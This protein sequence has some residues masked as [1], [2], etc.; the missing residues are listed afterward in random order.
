MDSGRKGS[1]KDGTEQAGGIYRIGLPRSDLKVTLD[2]VTLNPGFALGGWL[3]FEPMEEK[4]LVMGDLVLLESEISPVMQQAPAIWHT[5]NG[6]AQS[7]AALNSHHDVHAYYG[8]WRSGEAGERA[9]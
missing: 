6:A 9:S 7:P 5:D 2:G 4:A 1:R 8:S 3:A